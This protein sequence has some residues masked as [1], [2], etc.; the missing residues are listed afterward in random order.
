[1]TI[2][3]LPDLGEGLPDAEISQWYI[4]EGDVVKTDQP[5]VSMETAKAIV[6]VPSPHDGLITRLFGKPGDNFNKAVSWVK[7]ISGEVIVGTVFNNGIIKKITEFGCFVELF[8]N[9][10]GLVHISSIPRQEQDSFRNVYREGDKIK[11]I[12]IDYD[13]ITGRIR[14]KIVK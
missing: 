3:R 10:D 13:P 4:Q 7:M 8:P 14:L 2:F 12:V 5:L 9:F 11:V 1:M 6:D